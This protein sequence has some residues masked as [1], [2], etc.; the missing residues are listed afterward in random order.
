MDSMTLAATPNW[1][2]NQVMTINYNCSLFAYCAR[3]DIV[4]MRN[5]YAE[6]A[7]GIDYKTIKGAHK[8]RAAGCVFSPVTDVDKPFYKH[9]V[10]FGDDGT[11][12]MW[13][14]ANGKCVM[15]NNAHMKQ[16]ESGH[17]I[18]GI[19]WLKT[20]P[21]VIVS[22]SDNSVV[23]RWA[24]EANIVKLY[25][26]KARVF[27]QCIAASPHDKDI[28]AI[29]SKCGHVI[30]YSM[31]SGSGT[32]LGRVRCGDNDIMSLSWCPIPSD[33]IYGK[34]ELEPKYLVA[35]S[36]DYGVFIVNTNHPSKQK[37]DCACTTANIHLPRNPMSK[38]NHRFSKNYKK[39]NGWSVVCWSNPNT[40]I[41]TT[42]FAEVIT[43]QTEPLNTQKE[44]L[45][46]KFKLVHDRHNSK[47]ILSLACTQTSERDDS[48]DQ[49][50]WTLAGDRHLIR[51]SLHQLSLTL[52]LH[53][54]TSYVYALALSTVP[55]QSRLAIGV[56]EGK[57]LIWNMFKRAYLDMQEIWQK[58]EGKVMTLSFHPTKEGWL[59]YGTSSGSVGVIELG[60]RNKGPFVMYALEKSHHKGVESEKMA[61]YRLQWGPNIPIVGEDSNKEPC[62]L[63]GVSNGEVYVFTPSAKA[64][65]A[66]PPLSLKFHLDKVDSEAGQPK[67]TRRSDLC[68]KPDFTVLAVANENGSVYILSQELELLVT[69]LEHK[70]LLNTLAWHPAYVST[71]ESPYKNWLATGSDKI[72]VFNIDPDNINVSRQPVATLSLHSQRITCVSWNPHING[73]LLSTSYD[74]VAQIWDV[75]NQTPLISY[76]GHVSHVMTGLWSPLD[77]DLVMTGSADGTVHCW[78]MSK[79]TTTRPSDKKKTTK[80]EIDAALVATSDVTSEELT[81]DVREHNRM[82][83]NSSR[84]LRSVF[85]LTA[86]QLQS[87][88]H[89]HVLVNRFVTA[90]NPTNP[91]T[92]VTKQERDKK[93][94]GSHED[95]QESLVNGGDV[96]GAGDGGNATEEKDNENTLNGGKAVT[97]TVDESSLDTKD[98]TNTVAIIN[99]EETNESIEENTSSLYLNFFGNREDMSGLVQ[100]EL[101]QHINNKYI[102]GALGTALWLGDFNIVV[103]MAIEKEELTDEIVALSQTASLKL[104]RDCCEVYAKQLIAH[105]QILKATNY[106]L[107]IH[108]VEEAVKLL[109]SN[110]LYK[111]ALCLAKL[112]LPENHELIGK[113]YRAW[114]EYASS[115]GNYA[116][117]AHIHLL[118]EDGVSAMKVLNKANDIRFQY[119]SCI[120]A[121]NQS[122]MANTGDTLLSNCFKKSL[123]KVPL[124]FAKEMVES[125]PE[126]KHFLLWYHGRQQCVEML[127]N[128]AI[129]STWSQGQT[130]LNIIDKIHLEMENIEVSLDDIHALSELVNMCE[131]MDK[132][133]VLVYISGHLALSSVLPL[134]DSL[135]HIL[136]ALKVGYKLQ[137]RIIVF[138]AMLGAALYPQGPMETYP[139][140]NK[141]NSEHSDLVQS[142]RAFFCDSV[143]NWLHYC[144][145]KNVD[146]DKVLDIVQHTVENYIE[147]VISMD[148]VQ[149]YKAQAD[150]ATLESALCHQIVKD[151]ILKKV[152]SI[153][154]LD[155]L[156]HKSSHADRRTPSPYDNQ[157]DKI[158]NEKKNGVVE[159]EEKDEQA[160][161]NGKKEEGTVKKERKEEIETPKV[162]E[163]TK[164]P[165]VKE[166]KKEEIENGE[167]KEE[168][169][170]LQKEE[171]VE[172]K[173][174]TE[175]VIKENNEETQP[176][177]VKVEE[178]ENKK[179]I[180]SEKDTKDSEVSQVKD[181]DKKK[182]PSETELSDS[183]KIAEKKV[184]TNE[185]GE[186]EKPEEGNI[187]ALQDFEKATNPNYDI[188]RKSDSDDEDKEEL[189]R[190]EKVQRI[191]ELQDTILSFETTRIY[192]PNPSRV[193]DLVFKILKTLPSSDRVRE[194]VEL[195]NTHAEAFELA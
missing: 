91:I 55:D 98:E 68:W 15:V 26:V 60:N 145:D 137:S 159:Q 32:I 7:F 13:N 50:I 84:K 73:Q 109:L 104:W 69:L 167:D 28:V 115:H 116:L 185:D 187:N 147:D 33:V 121:L 4:V 184:K 10:S 27:P 30:I 78:R 61:V 81:P 125:H 8:D 158:E 154:N 123:E 52:D 3:A 2:L 128:T 49:V 143:I 117:A 153:E 11:L 46:F 126:N 119:Y 59:G 14:L 180:E 157:N 110:D 161:E 120:L 57:I 22:V 133:K 150:L 83:D 156:K 136:L 190:E 108:K 177:E 16:I 53:T 65:K 174:D 181:H 99:T 36:K 39:D 168:N 183:E 19:D 107:A 75:P 144:E 62:W 178:N 140:L 45:Q 37:L 169:K 112:R 9:L 122:N 146:Q 87:G 42:R 186:S 151:N 93:E 66:T 1:F 193:F 21:H 114:A 71:C 82:R 35:G 130:G 131:G 189:T 85:P 77:P 162:Q 155:L 142:I 175:D 24:L 97:G 111:E 188:D 70:K 170:D 152:D 163:E 88:Q 48:M 29:G 63:Y 160:Y 92:I 86:N 94:T 51:Y 148:T 76:H 17:K 44:G 12:R 38:H 129:L 96:H 165:E 74:S 72:K 194:L 141:N 5:A 100:A 113:G 64:F 106:L 127:E 195:M 166:K 80:N 25:I 43:F 182:R 172:E 40:L 192:S 54:C 58:I 105:G 124:T 23:V 191:K 102:T 138:P 31:K 176:E 179:E 47:P 90:T 67:D 103:K 173:T 118:L 6:N 56:G 164:T 95:N 41:T 139:L 20:D 135:K 89:L 149:Y 132:S 134:P 171:I 34:T 79:Q 18:V 101:K